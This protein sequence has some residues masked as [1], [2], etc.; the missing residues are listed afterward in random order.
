MEAFVSREKL[1]GGISGA[2]LRSD[3]RTGLAAVWK[4]MINVMLSNP[5]MDRAPP[6]FR[7]RND[8]DWAG[9]RQ[10]TSDDENF[11]SGPMARPVARFDIGQGLSVMKIA[12]ICLPA[13]LLV[14]FGGCM[15]AKDCVDQCVIGCRNECYAE[16]AWCKCKSNYNDVEYKCDFGKG[17][18]DGYIAVASGGGTCLPA[19]PPQSYWHFE[20]Q[21]PEGQERQLAWF[22]GYSYGAIYAEQE[23]ISDWSRVV[24]APTLPPYRKKRPPKQSSAADADMNF[25]AP[26]SDEGPE[27]YVQPMPPE[28]SPDA[29]SASAGVIELGEPLD[30]DGNTATAKVVRWTDGADGY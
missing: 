1:R 15:M 2:P 7:M 17:F 14:S 13:L 19:L 4:I 16:M 11:D 24:T 8:F 20:Y 22:N 10:V 29:P 12:H 26:P 30:E 5:R 25:N 28:V 23:G 27:P 6:P 21:N 18:R 9:R 3:V